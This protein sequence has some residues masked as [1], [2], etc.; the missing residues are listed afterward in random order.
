MLRDIKNA[1]VKFSGFLGYTYD[2]LRRYLIQLNSF[3]VKLAFM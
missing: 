1:P 2:T 3:V